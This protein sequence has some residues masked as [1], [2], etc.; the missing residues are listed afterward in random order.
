[1]S[2]SRQLIDLSHTITEGMVT[3]PGLPAPVIGVH[4]TRE[5]AEEIY[6]PGITFTIGQLSICTNTGTYLDVP[7]HRFA[8]GHDLAA[9]RWNGW[10]GSGGLSGSTRADHDRSGGRRTCRSRRTRCAHPHRPLPSP[11]SVR[12]TPDLS[13]HPHPLPLRPMP[14][15]TPGWPA[16]GSTR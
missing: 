12:S 15:S 14:W 10:R 6:G 13:G 5:A 11:R 1:M 4:L 3:Y 7:F 16:S 9:L 8:H 2:T